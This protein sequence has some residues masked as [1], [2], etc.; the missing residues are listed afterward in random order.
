MK[1]DSFK[2]N[3]F[4]FNR[5]NTFND[6]KFS[7]K[8]KLVYLLLSLIFLASCEDKKEEE[9]KNEE[10]LITPPIKKQELDDF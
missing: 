6:D 4:T 10:E 7:K 5:T 9:E 1:V 3:I 2:T 8:H